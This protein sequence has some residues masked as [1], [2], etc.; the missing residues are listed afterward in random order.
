MTLINIFFTLTRGVPSDLLPVG[1]PRQ[2]LRPFQEVFAGSVP[3][4]RLPRRTSLPPVCALVMT[5]MVWGLIMTRRNCDY[6]DHNID[7]HDK[8]D[9]V[10]DHDKDNFDYLDHDIDGHNKDDLAVILIDHDKDK[11][12]QN[13]DQANKKV[14]DHGTVKSSSSVRVDKGER[15]PSLLHLRS[16]SS[17]YRQHHSWL[18]L[19]FFQDNTQ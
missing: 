10:V 16:F 7:D 18:F 11:G 17:N 4:S 1:S 9:V 8:D 13:I 5:T 15:A 19:P 6:L 14:I 2:R 12:A 3:R